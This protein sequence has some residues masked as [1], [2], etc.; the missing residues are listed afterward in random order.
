VELILLVVFLDQKLT[1]TMAKHILLC[2]K[3]LISLP[4][5]F[6]VKCVGMC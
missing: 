4:N 2:V 5:M 6:A 3:N 1:K